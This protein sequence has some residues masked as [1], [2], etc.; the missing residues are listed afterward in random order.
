VCDS[1]GLEYESAAKIGERDMETRCQ[2]SRLPA[3]HAN[4]KRVFSVNVAHSTRDSHM[5]ASQP[6]LDSDVVVE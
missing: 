2:R 6:L 3:L 4:H 1:G 5:S